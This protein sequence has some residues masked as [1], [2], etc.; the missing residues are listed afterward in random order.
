MGC[1]KHLD[2]PIQPRDLVTLGATPMTHIAVDMDD[3]VVDFVGGLITAVKTEYDVDITHEQLAATGWDL[4]PLL[5]PIIGY[6]WWT[7]LRE[8]EWLWANFPV[9]NGAIGG[10]NKLRRQGHYLELVTSKPTWAEHNVWKWLGKWRPPFNAVTIVGADDRKVDFTNAEI[11]IDDKPSNLQEF[12][13]QSR[14]AVLFARPHNGT[15]VLSE[16]FRPGRCFRANNWREVIQRVN[17][18]QLYLNEN[19]YEDITN[20][21]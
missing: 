1:P 11:L 20:G 19:E 9:I 8:R 4:H 21:R 15:A 18:I 13:D 5:D 7:W 10:L 17:T 16:V 6:S 12:L 2:R 14:H 3:V